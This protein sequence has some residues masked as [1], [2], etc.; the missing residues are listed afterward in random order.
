ME[1]IQTLIIIA[2]FVKERCMLTLGQP[3]HDS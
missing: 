3:N 1:T 2:Y